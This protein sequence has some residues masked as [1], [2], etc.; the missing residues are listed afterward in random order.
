MYLCF[1]C[2]AY[3]IRHSWDLAPLTNQNGRYFY[4][5]HLAN[6]YRPIAKKHKWRSDACII[7]YGFCRTTE[8]LNPYP[9]VQCLFYTTVFDKSNSASGHLKNV[10]SQ[11]STHQ[12]TTTATTQKMAGHG[13]RNTKLMGSQSSCSWSFY[14]TLC[15]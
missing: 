10:R 9:S 1:P 5:T 11:Q 2:A 14:N 13:T 7:A 4:K 3:K 8:M 15:E 6:L 12:T